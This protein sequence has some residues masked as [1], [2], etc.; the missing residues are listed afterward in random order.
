VKNDRTAKQGWSANK[1]HSIM[2]LICTLTPTLDLASKAA[3]Q[4][5]NI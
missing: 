5:A 1:L 4:E 2:D 3:K